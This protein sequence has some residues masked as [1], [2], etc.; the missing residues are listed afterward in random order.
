[1]ER[2]AGNYVRLYCL[3]DIDKVE[4]LS[5]FKTIGDLIIHSA[6][7]TERVLYFSVSSLWCIY[8]I[9]V[10]GIK[11]K[12]KLDPTKQLCAGYKVRKLRKSFYEYTDNKDARKIKFKADFSSRTET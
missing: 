11:S 10:H 4:S 5:D 9:P 7:P 2:T 8:T 12:K 6:F 3:S 1:M